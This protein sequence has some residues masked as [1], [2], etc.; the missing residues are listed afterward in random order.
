MLCPDLPT[1]AFM[2]PSLLWFSAILA[3]LAGMGRTLKKYPEDHQSP[4]FEPNVFFFHWQITQPF[5]VQEEFTQKTQDLN[6]ECKDSIP[7]MQMGVKLGCYENL[8]H[9]ARSS[10]N[11]ETSVLVIFCRF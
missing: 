6:P 11:M 8:N 3:V 7:I 5:A 4:R 2:G 9:Y 10:S 1:F